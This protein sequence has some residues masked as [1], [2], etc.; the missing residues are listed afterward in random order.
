MFP[1]SDDEDQVVNSDEKDLFPSSVDEDHVPNNSDEEDL[2][3]SSGDEQVGDLANGLTR[4]GNYCDSDD[5]SRFSEEV[6]IRPPKRPTLPN[7]CKKERAKSL[8]TEYKAPPEER[9]EP[10]HYYLA[11]MWGEHLRKIALPLTS[12][13]PAPILHKGGIKYE[14]LYSEL[15]A[16]KGKR[17]KEDAMGQHYY[18]SWYLGVTRGRREINRKSALL[19]IGDF[20]S[21]TFERGAHKTVSRLKLL[22]SPSSRPP[23]GGKDFCFHQMQE[24]NFELIEDHGHLGCGFIH[25]GYLFELLGKSTPA[26]RVFAIQVRIIG[27][28][29]VGVAKGMI[30]V[31]ETMP[32]DKIQIPSSMVKV[33]KSKT[34]PLHTYVAINIIQHFPSKAQY[35]MGRLFNDDQKDPSIP[36]VN[37]LNPPCKDAWRVLCCKGVDQSIIDAYTAH[38]AANSNSDTGQEQISIDHAKFSIKHANFVGVSDSTGQIPSG[39]VFLTGMGNRTPS[40]VF[41]TR[42]PCTEGRDGI[43]VEVAS[44][45]HM[46]T[47]AFQFLDSIGFGAVVFPIGENPLP[48]TINDGDLDG[49]LYI[50]IWDENILES[51]TND[52]EHDENLGVILSD[53]I[54]GHEFEHTINGIGHNALVDKKLQ[55]NPDLYGVQTGPNR[56]TEVRMT[57]EEILDGRDLLSEVT[58]HRSTGGALR[59]PKGKKQE[60]FS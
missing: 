52:T 37:D 7:K 18:K 24:S 47:E 4:N 35:T 53:D 44:W 11:D 22:V 12:G 32:R 15:V 25:P 23:G 26:K 5:E 29:S 57:R 20:E 13:P 56:E 41:L 14:I 34:K 19:A 39:Y 48:P 33:N 21:L 1:S 51:I 50:C 58:N 43:V 16:R 40:R 54:V 28:S 60:T 55:E 42:S 36:M 45:Q 2:F 31:K 59:R 6:N 30:F 49:D 46:P 27:P 8:V 9:A 38:L 3:P 17:F 10:E